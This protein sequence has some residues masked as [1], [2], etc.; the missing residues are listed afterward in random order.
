MASERKNGARAFVRDTM[1]DMRMRKAGNKLDDGR[2]VMT[3]ANKMLR[4]LTSPYGAGN[5]TSAVDMA[6]A[7]GANDEYVHF[8]RSLVEVVI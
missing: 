7:R 1:I 8:V 3:E 6:Q 2:R 4:V 5:Y